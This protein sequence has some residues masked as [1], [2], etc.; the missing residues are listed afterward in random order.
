MDMNALEFRDVDKRYGRGPRE[1]LALAGVRFAVPAGQA[2]AVLGASGS[3]KTTLLNLAAGLDHADAGT[4][5]LMGRDLAGM[6]QAALADWRGRN[7][8]FVFQM[9][10]L[11]PTLTAGENVEFPL[12]LAGVPAAARRHRAADLLARAGLSDLARRFPDEL[13]TGQ[14]Q[15][16][17]L[18][19][20]LARQPAIVLLD[21]PTSALDSPR[22]DELIALLLELNRTERA[23]VLLATHDSRIAARLTQSLTIV[24]GRIVSTEENPIP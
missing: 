18:L 22:A 17:A 13:S 11:L 8:G 12:T 6:S 7:V 16:V 15:R 20:A 10:N 2:L 9:L 19:R 21:E 23:T 4:V 14:Q 3:G 1:T 24:D 5:T